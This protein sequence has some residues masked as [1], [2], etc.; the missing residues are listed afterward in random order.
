MNTFT[1]YTRLRTKCVPHRTEIAMKFDYNY[2]T[3][4]TIFTSDMLL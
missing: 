4:A 3:M 1:M 2:D